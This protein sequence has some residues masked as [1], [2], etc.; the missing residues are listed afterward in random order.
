MDVL[1]APAPANT[2]SPAHTSPALGPSPAP[3]PEPQPG[4]HS[5]PPALSQD[6]FE[7]GQP[8][9]VLQQRQQQLRDLPR[10]Q[11]LSNLNPL[12]QRRYLKLVSQQSPGAVQRQAHSR[13]ASVAPQKPVPG[14]VEV[15]QSY[16]QQL[17]N[18]NNPYASIPQSLV[19][20][21]GLPQAESS[22]QKSGYQ[23][24]LGDK[25]NPQ[26]AQ[27][28][29]EEAIFHTGMAVMGMIPPLGAAGA[30]NAVRAAEAVD[31]AA[32][33]AEAVDAGRAAVDA[34]GA[35]N[36]ATRGGSAATHAGSVAFAEPDYVQ[37][38]LTAKHLKG[39]CGLAEAMTEE[40]A[41]RLGGAWV[42]PEARPMSDCSGLVSKDGT[43]TYRF[44]KFKKNGMA[45]G[46]TQANLEE[47]VAAPG[48]TRLIRVRNVHIDI[49]S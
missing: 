40:Q 38:L 35:L 14:P 13:D 49:K 48:S 19:N 46:R 5:S 42:G 22:L 12:D 1:N 30:T 8:A 47:L 25:A 11:G 45:A 15:A 6:V 4:S 9:D 37:A 39:N 23:S 2:Q 41:N 21:S 3:C 7:K 24:G 34:G 43:R 44:P 27:T 26:L 32:H 33:G 36:A 28:A 31:A 16:Y 10:R 29:H 18:Q 17:I 20:L